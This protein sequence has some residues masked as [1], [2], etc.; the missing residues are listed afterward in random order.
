[1]RGYLFQFA[2]EMTVFYCAAFLVKETNALALLLSISVLQE[3]I[4]TLTA[5]QSLSLKK[6]VCS[7]LCSDFI[8][9]F[10]KEMMYSLHG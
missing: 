5:W 2:R 6:R 7:S 1:M 4:E 10:A 3:A 9:S 8:L